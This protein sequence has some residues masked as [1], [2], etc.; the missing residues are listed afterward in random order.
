MSYL[1]NDN[2]FA[3]DESDSQDLN[4]IE[5]D[6][7]D[8]DIMTFK[9][10][11]NDD[12]KSSDNE[13][14]FIKRSTAATNKNRQDGFINLNNNNGNLYYNIF[15]E[16]SNGFIIKDGGENN[17]TL[18]FKEIDEKKGLNENIEKE[19]IEKEKDIINNH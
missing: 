9:L 19:K 1:K 18:L 2:I 7:F 16:Q 14:Y 10:N 3:Y 13:R 8:L 5:D 17:Q 11:E 6:K 15:E 12:E 4:K